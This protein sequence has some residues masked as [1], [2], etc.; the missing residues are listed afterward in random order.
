M[1]GPEKME[2]SLLHSDL[3]SCFSSRKFLISRHSDAM[4]Y[5][6]QSVDLGFIP[7]VESYQKTLKNGIHSFPAW[8]LAFKEWC[9][10]QA[11]KFACCVL[12]QGT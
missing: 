1:L 6:L 12:G 3:P 7:L 11:N 9:G 8:C 2:F 4:A 10:E 5:A